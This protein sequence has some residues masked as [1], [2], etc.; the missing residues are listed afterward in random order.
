MA[1]VPQR[2]PAVDSGLMGGAE[3]ILNER[4]RQVEEE[5]WTPE[6]DDKFTAGELVQAA[7]CYAFVPLQRIMLFSGFWPWDITWFK[8]TTR[9]RDL[10]RAGALIAAEI[11]RL[12]RAQIEALGVKKVN[13]Q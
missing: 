2:T 7:I 1:K 13:H 5:G 6:H 12:K 11:D 10:V 8:P 3:L 9:I 4:E